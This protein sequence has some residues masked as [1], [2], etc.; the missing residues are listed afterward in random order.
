MKYYQEISILPDPEISPYFIWQ[1]L[2][3][4]L[5]IA[6]ADVKNQHGI[7]GIG[8]SFPEYRY[9]ENNGKCFATLGAKLRIFA[10]TK[11]DLFTLDIKTWLNRLTDYVHIK[12]I[13]EVPENAI[14]VIFMRHKTKG[15]ARIE[16]DMQSFAKRM[17]EKTNKPLTECL[18]K[19][20]KTKPMPNYSKLPYINLESEQTKKQNPDKA[21]KFPMFIQRIE[22]ELTEEIKNAEGK[23]NSYGLGVNKNSSIV[24]EF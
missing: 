2:Y 1:K 22:P 6:L 9:E 7:E 24:F 11:E 23:F 19:L 13:R 10:K 4:Q 14:P 18:A 8:V 12:S 17:A 16:K 21:R 5:H 15:A 3:N 20:A